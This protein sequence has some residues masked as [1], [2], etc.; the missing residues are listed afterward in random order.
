MGAG[1]VFPWAKLSSSSI[2][3]AFIKDNTFSI[4]G[5]TIGELIFSKLDDFYEY[6]E[7]NFET[8]IAVIESIM[9]YT[10]AISDLREARYGKGQTVRNRSLQRGTGGKG[11]NT[12]CTSVRL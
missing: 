6:G 4:N 12:G 9:N 2:K 5:H 7:A 10:E 3:D 11:K 1:F 8:F